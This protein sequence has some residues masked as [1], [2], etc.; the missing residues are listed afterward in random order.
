LTNVEMRSA[1]FGRMLQLVDT[2]AHLYLDHFK[3]DIDAVMQ[4][5]ADNGVSKILL[6]NIDS[7]TTDALLGLTDS[8]ANCLPMMGLH[9][10]SVKETVAE[11]L[12]HVRTE[13]DTGKYIA[14]GEIGIDLYWDKTF[15][16]EQIAAFEKQMEW[17]KEMN[18]PVAIHCRDSFDEIFTSVEKI[19]DGNL[20]GVLHCFTG[21]EEQANRAIDLGLHLGLGGVL[22]FKNS[23]VDK[24]IEDIPLEKLILETDSPYLAPTPFR[25]KRNESSYTLNVAQKLA[26][27]KQI[28]LDKV[29]SVTTQSAHTLFNL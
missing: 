1:I 25:G 24:A 23:G 21:N 6:P 8:Y 15:I 26:D 3:D 18:L 20:K 2:H 17:A 7:S 16:N 29:A 13:L 14:V 5:A 28:T 9:P 12:K 19:Q 27:I 10:C 4:R 22:T 11:E